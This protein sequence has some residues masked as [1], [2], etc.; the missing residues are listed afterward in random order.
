VAGCTPKPLPVDQ[1][2]LP[3][4]L[5]ALRKKLA[6]HV[7]DVWA[8]ERIA[9]GWTY[10]PAR[11]AAAKKHPCLVPWAELPESEKVHDRNTAPGTLRAVPA[12]GY[13]TRKG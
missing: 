6:E 5:N 3:E 13:T 12:L 1:I 9:Q 7:H 8:A 11:D 10:G 2:D 4:D